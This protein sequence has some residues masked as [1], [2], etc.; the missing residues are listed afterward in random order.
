MTKCIVMFVYKSTYYTRSHAV[1]ITFFLCE[2]CVYK[3]NLTN[4]YVQCLENNDLRVLTVF[5]QFRLHIT[6]SYTLSIIPAVT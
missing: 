5:F 2:W 4:K 6:S 3:T 1:D